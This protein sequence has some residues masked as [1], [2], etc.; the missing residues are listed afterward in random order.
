MKIRSGL[1]GLRVSRLVNLFLFSFPFGLDS[2]CVAKL[3][4]GCVDA[5]AMYRLRRG[6]LSTRLWRGATRSVQYYTSLRVC[7]FSVVPLSF[8]IVCCLL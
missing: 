2:C 5:R 7:V 8:F 3:T 4:Y 1:L 6:I